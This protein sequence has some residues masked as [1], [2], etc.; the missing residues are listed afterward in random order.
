MEARSPAPGSWY[1]VSLPLRV[2]LTAIAEV[3]IIAVLVLT[4][5]AFSGAVIVDLIVKPKDW[6]RLCR[7]HFIQQPRRSAAMVRWVAVRIM[8]PT[9][10][11]VGRAPMRLE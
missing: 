2:I 3:S 7:G 4:W 1:A 11:P 8:A 6:R 5:V 9:G 10:Y